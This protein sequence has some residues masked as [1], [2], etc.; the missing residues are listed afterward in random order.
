MADDF[1]MIKDGSECTRLTDRKITLREPTFP[2]DSC[3]CSLPRPLLSDGSRF[4]QIYTTCQALL[5]AL[6]DDAISW[7]FLS[8]SHYPLSPSTVPAPDCGTR[9]APRYLFLYATTGC[10]DNLRDAANSSRSCICR[11]FYP[12]L[13]RLEYSNWRKFPLLIRSIAFFLFTRLN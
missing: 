12:M 10:S 9:T 3:G 5:F 4:L 2:D 8:F 1:S 11:P 13:Q 7:C 6:N